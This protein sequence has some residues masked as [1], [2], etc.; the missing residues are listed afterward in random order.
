MTSE[1]NHEDPPNI[2]QW[3]NEVN[4]C[5]PLEKITYAIRDSPQL[6]YRIWDPWITYIESS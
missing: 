2:T 5:A 1:W 4:Y 6:F 3:I